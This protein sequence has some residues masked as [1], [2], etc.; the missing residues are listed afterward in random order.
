MIEIAKA[1]D[2]AGGDH[3]ALVHAE[4]RRRGERETQRCRDQDQLGEGAVQRP[5][6]AR[7]GR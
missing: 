5:M 6:L 2:A 7:M 4:T 1:E 3:V